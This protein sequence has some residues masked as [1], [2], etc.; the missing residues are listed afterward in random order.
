MWHS[1]YRCILWTAAC[2][3]RRRHTCI[4]CMIYMYVR[5]HICICMYVY[6]CNDMFFFVRT[7]ACRWR[8]RPGAPRLRRPRWSTSLSKWMTV[9]VCCYKMCSL[10]V[11]CVLLLFCS[12]TPKMVDVS[13]QVND[14]VCVC[15][16]RMCSLAIEC[17]LFLFCSK[18][19]KMVD[20]SVQVNDGVCVCV[21]VWVYVCVSLS[22][23]V[24][25]T[26]M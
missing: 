9:C 12:K 22:L 13:V 19:P 18:T 4:S 14:G 10:A 15:C 1:T 2:L 16:Y 20:V 23:C 25:H 21:W 6:I 8:R 5:V 26:H 11:E 7:A 3:G 17:V 24:L